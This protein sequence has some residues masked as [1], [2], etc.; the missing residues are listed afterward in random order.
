MYKNR[1]LFPKTHG[2]LLIIQYPELAGDYPAGGR[3]KLKTDPLPGSLV[4]E[5]V[6]P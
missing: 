4:T 3:V 1:Q 6:P 5:T 2:S